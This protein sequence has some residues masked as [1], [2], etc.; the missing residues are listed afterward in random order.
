MRWGGYGQ[1]ADVVL[2][3]DPVA[4]HDAAWQEDEASVAQLKGVIPAV[5]GQISRQ[6]VEDLV[7]RSV[8]VVRRFLA[9]ARR[10]LDERQALPRPEF[11]RLDGE[12][13][14]IVVRPA[15]PGLQAYGRS[16]P[17]SIAAAV[18][19]AWLGVLAGECDVRER[20]ILPDSPADPGCI[21]ESDEG[22]QRG[23]VGCFLGSPAF[24]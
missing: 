7:L 8:R 3:P 20:A 2:A 10:V 23:R 19:L 21:T 4:V 18:R 16:C 15:L 5:E 6:H 13:D 1:Q 12:V 9:S 14:A 17:F 22:A 11:S 24:E